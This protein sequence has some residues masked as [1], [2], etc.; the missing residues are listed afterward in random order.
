MSVTLQNVTAVKTSTQSFLAGCKL[1]NQ[2]ILQCFNPR[3]HGLVPDRVK[4]FI[5]NVWMLV[6]THFPT[7]WLLGHLRSG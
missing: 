7:E 6:P 2:E 3:Y 1:N 4:G 5:S